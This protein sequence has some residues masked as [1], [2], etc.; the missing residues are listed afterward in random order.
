MLRSKIR[1]MTSIIMQ[2]SNR[3]DTAAS[4]TTRQ[5][6]IISLSDVLEPM[7]S[8][9]NIMPTGISTL[10]FERSAISPGTRP[11]HSRAMNRIPDTNT[12]GIIALSFREITS[13]STNSA[14]ITR[15]LC[16]ISNSNI[17][18]SQE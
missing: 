2:S 9:M 18:T 3:Y 5:F 8:M 14:A 6:A 16:I 13:P 7:L 12:A 10:S 1:L 4:S 11:L 15:P 17:R